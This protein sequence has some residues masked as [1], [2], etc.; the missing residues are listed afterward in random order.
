MLQL[1]NLWALKG[2]HGTRDRDPE[3]GLPESAEKY[4]STEIG[5]RWSF[6]LLAPRRAR[7]QRIRE[8]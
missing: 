6:Q 3:R 5:V 1:M 8:R 7:K 2:D 4:D